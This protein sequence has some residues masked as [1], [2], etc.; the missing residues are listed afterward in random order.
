MKTL[1]FSD[2]HLTTVFKKNKYEF[3]EKIISSVD[4]VIIAGD[5]WEGKLITFDEFV[6]SEWKKLFPLLKSKK[7]VYIFGNHD[8]R[9][10]SDNRASLFSDKQCE[11]YE[12][13]SGSI[14]FFI[15]HGD[16]KKLK[17]S[18]I[19]RVV[20]TTHMS[21]KFFT[22]YC[23]EKLEHMLVKILGRNILQ[24]LFNK[25]NTVLK[26][27]EAMRLNDHEILIC[28]HT[29]A[30]MLDIKTHYANTGIIRHGIGQF[31]T[32]EN[33]KIELHEEKY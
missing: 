31:I 13:K 6:N 14:N 7:T 21:E 9:N 29:H 27:D 4:R 22:K 28:G 19:K 30:A 24:I 25:Y 23:H 16:S 15:K 17:Y 5:F 32:I 26:T 12:L 3:L 11:A 8:K 1:I 2:T 20:K 33:G 18:F 10:Y